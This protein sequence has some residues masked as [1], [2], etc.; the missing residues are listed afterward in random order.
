MDVDRYFDCMYVYVP[1]SSSEMLVFVSTRTFVWFP[2]LCKSGVVVSAHTP[3]TNVSG[4]GGWVPGT[5]CLLHSRPEHPVGEGLENTHRIVHRHLHVHT[6]SLHW[7]LEVGPK[8]LEILSPAR[9]EGRRKGKER[10][11]E[12]T[13]EGERKKG[14]RR[15]KSGSRGRKAGGRG[16]KKYTRM[17]EGGV[18][19]PGIGVNCKLLYGCS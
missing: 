11:R 12:V 9:K 18:G 6:K 4:T 15:E 13:R 19:F 1:C 3:S 17:P 14:E 5:Y 10:W 2:E 8:R 16:A 7:E